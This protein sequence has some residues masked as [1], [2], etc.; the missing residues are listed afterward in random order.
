MGDF[1]SFFSGMPGVHIQR[2]Q[3]GQDAMDSFGAI[4]LQ[5]ESLRLSNAGKH[6]EAR[7]KA[8]ESLEARLRVHGPKSLQVGV[9]LQR[10]A[11]VDG[12]LGNHEGALEMA[13]RAMIVREGLRG[14]HL[15]A[16]VSRYDS[17][18]PDK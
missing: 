13:K 9:A 8:V 12:D 15:D 1:S 7:A 5:H 14:E 11:E 16:A 17:Q 10:L 4:D 3:S 2:C 18:A 6:Q